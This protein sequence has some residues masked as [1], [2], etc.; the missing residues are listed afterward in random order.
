MV[1][2][3]VKMTPKDFFLYVGVM[4]TLYISAVSLLVLWFQYINLLFPSTLNSFVD[5]F[6]G[7]IRS[8]M[9]A[10][11]IVFPLFI[12]L[13]RYVN[14]EIRRDSR[15]SDLGIRRWL[16]YL[17]LFI[18]GATVAIDLIVLVNTFLGGDL[19]TRFI[20]KV[21]S[22]FVVIGG[23]FSYYFY[24]L[25]GRWAGNPKAARS[26][27]IAVAL[28]VFISIVG[29]FFITGSP[30]S[31]RELR[32]DRERVSDLQNIQWQIVDH[33]QS[34]EVLPKTLTDL[35][36]S[37]TGYVAPNDPETREAYTYR[38]TGAR[39]FA[40]CA[41]FNLESS[42]KSESLRYPQFSTE[43]TSWAHSEGETCFERTIDPDRFPPRKE[44]PSRIR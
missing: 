26:V 15:K 7:A 41:E 9:A 11:I 17:T 1:E 3:K 5:P 21:L 24:D 12:Y 14:R 27:S 22:I 43:G 29:G 10:L 37:I 32:I 31:Q 8:S 6:S 2:T 16:I 19:T 4:I 44:I 33:W 23:G 28:V 30:A 40:L 39:S 42:G 35:E 36:D 25:K 18:G 34:K 13:S 20:L 38:V